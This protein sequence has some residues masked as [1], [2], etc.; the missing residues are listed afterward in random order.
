MSAILPGTYL[1]FVN[2]Y[3]AN[4]S[5]EQLTTGRVTVINGEGTPDEKMETVT[6]PLRHPGDLALMYS[7]VYP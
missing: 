3:G 6:V 1:V 2:Y 4:D 5:D 7:F